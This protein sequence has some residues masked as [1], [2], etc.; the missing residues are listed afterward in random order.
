VGSFITFKKLAAVLRAFCE[1]LLTTDPSPF[2]LKVMLPRWRIPAQHS[3]THCTSPSEMP[4][5]L[6]AVLRKPNPIRIKHYLNAL[7]R[8][9]CVRGRSSY[10]TSLKSSRSFTPSAVTH[11]LPF[12]YLKAKG[13]GS[14]NGPDMQLHN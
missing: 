6:K 1:P 2:W 7:T 3:N 14:D 11:P 9:R 8:T 10:L 13:E 12:R 4:N 5:W